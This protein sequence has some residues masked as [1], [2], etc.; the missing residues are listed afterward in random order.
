MKNAITKLTLMFLVAAVTL[1]VALVIPDAASAQQSEWLVRLSLTTDPHVGTVPGPGYSFAFGIRQGATEGYGQ[2]EGDQIAPPDAMTGVNAYFHYPRS[3][4]LERNL[5]TSV[6]GPEPSINWLLVI[7]S[8]EHTAD[9][10]ATLSWDMDDIANVPAEYNTLELQDR[11][12]R[13]LAD[14]RAE[15]SY[16]FALQS[17]QAVSFHIVVARA[18]DG[19][20]RISPTAGNYNLYDPD[21]ITA[22]I[23][24]GEARGIISIVDDDLFTLSEG[25]DYKV[26]GTTLTVLKGYLEGKLPAVG[27][28][29]DLSIEFDA[30]NQAVLAITAVS[31]MPPAEYSLTVSSTAGGTVTPPEGSAMRYGEGTVVQ[32]VA[33][34][35]EGYRFVRWTGDVDR[36]ADVNSATTT[37]TVQGDYSITA[38]FEG[39]GQPPSLVVIGVIIALLLAAGLAI[40]ALRRRRV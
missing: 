11:D 20:P 25:S 2:A 9:T 31:T 7:K 3:P 8:A 39:V 36:V 30:C 14:M 13:V 4:Q 26:A 18:A 33:E 10:Q 40:Y 22:T 37:V 19:C 28:S 6:V 38:S 24:W 29:V 17:E 15:A 5:V 27:D 21:D 16:T 32:L 23:T 12:G 34:P 35:E 1:V